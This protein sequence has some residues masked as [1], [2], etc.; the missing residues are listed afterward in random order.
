MENQ[1]EQNKYQWKGLGEKYNTPEFIA[2]AEQ[3]FQSSPLKEEE[4]G[5]S[6]LA[7]R[8]FMKLMGASVALSTA[9]CVRRPVQ[10]IIPYNKRPAEVVP[11]IANYY[12]SSF[13]D[14]RE[15]FGV[16]V[17]TR[18]GRPIHIEGNPSYPSS[19]QGL[20]ARASAQILNLYDPDRIRTPIINSQDPKKRGNKLSIPRDWESLDK[21]VA[22]QFKKGGVRVLSS[23]SAS[24]TLTKLLKQFVSNVNGKLT[25]WSPLNHDIL[26]EAQRLSYGSAVVPKY[27]S[28]IHI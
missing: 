10:K 7:R 18:E 15:G 3:E 28:L 13:F 17:K 24:P 2:K 1:T 25:Y 9:A 26:M 23:G 8:Q 27:L 16:T 5:K 22:E 21:K 6:G 12:A 11:G 19:G 20:S 14:G 4:V